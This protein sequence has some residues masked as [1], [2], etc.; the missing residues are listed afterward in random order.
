MRSLFSKANNVLN[1]NILETTFNPVFVHNLHR[2]AEHKNQTT[3]KRQWKEDVANEVIGIKVLSMTVLASKR[4]FEEEKQ[5]CEVSWSTFVSMRTWGNS[6]KLRLS[7]ISIVSR[8]TRVIKHKPITCY[9]A[10][11]APSLPSTLNPFN[12]AAL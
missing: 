9:R 4:K 5:L 12:V 3:G 11:P 2:T 10:A 1:L 6:I 7:H 8:S